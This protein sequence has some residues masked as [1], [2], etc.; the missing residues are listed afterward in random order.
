MKPKR[1]QIRGFTYGD[2]RSLDYGV[3]LIGGGG[4]Y[5]VPV[6]DTETVSIPGRNGDLVFDNGRFANV[7]ISA[8]CWIEDNFRVYFSGLQSAML[9][10][11]GYQR[12]EMSF[13]KDYYRMARYTGDTTQT[14]VRNAGVFE[15]TFDCK[16]QKFLFSG[17][18]ATTLT[19]TGSIFNPTAMESKPL[20][21]VYGSGVLG[22]GSE[23]LTI[24]S[25]SYDSMTL[26][27]ELKDAYTDGAN[28]NSYVELSSGEWP[29]LAPG[30][31]NIS[32][33]SGI[34]KVEIT[35]RWWTL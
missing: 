29:V 8:T 25:H 26:D 27:C 20:I 35:P 32:L 14:A 15:L 18:K 28:L 2:V 17:E 22:I 4:P 11:T 3:F 19:E 7:A 6:R 21:E 33:G 34:T 5:V 31:N 9:A 1:K 12:L 13:W 10:L 30:L 23:T 24:T 16:P